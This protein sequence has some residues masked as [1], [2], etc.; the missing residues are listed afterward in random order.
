MATSSLKLDDVSS[1]KHIEFEA[2]IFSALDS[3]LP[4][5]LSLTLPPSRIEVKHVN[6]KRRSRH[7]SRTSH[8]PSLHRSSSL[9]FRTL[10][11]ISRMPSLQVPSFTDINAPHS[12]STPRRSLHQISE[13]E[14][15]TF[16]LKLPLR[17][18]HPNSPYVPWET[19]VR[20]KILCPSNSSPLLSTTVEAAVVEDNAHGSDDKLNTRGD[21]KPI[22]QIWSTLKSAPKSL[23]SKCQ[24]LLN[25]RTKDSSP[26]LPE[27]SEEEVLDSKADILP[28]IIDISDSLP[29]P[30]SPTASVRSADTHTLAIWLAERHRKFAEKDC[31][32]AKIMTIEDYERLGSWIKHRDVQVLSSRS[33]YHCSIADGDTVSSIFIMESEHDLVPSPTSEQLPS[34]PRSAVSTSSRPTYGPKRIVEED[35][36]SRI[37][38]RSSLRS[39]LAERSL[40]MPTAAN[41]SVGVS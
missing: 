30:Y 6:E 32:S 36:L 9:V 10:P 13:T 41:S 23:K 5:P 29:T 28:H 11:P 18:V 34:T 4:A 39:Y 8:R 38:H 27:E 25:P 20:Q 17:L 1:H 31:E 15:S 3:T 37:V 22:K 2:S 40:S 21:K 16:K 24:R 19:P 33:S 12:L 26:V 7:D 35:R 14:P